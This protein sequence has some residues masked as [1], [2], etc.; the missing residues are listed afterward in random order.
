[1]QSTELPL[2]DAF[3]SQLHSCSLIEKDYKEWVHLVKSGL[4]A[5]QTFAKL[6]LSKPLPSRME[7][8]QNLPEISEEE[9][10]GSVRDILH[11]CNKKDDVPILEAMQKVIALYNN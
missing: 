4:T 11:W 9:N 6:K 2:F 1:M 10:S 8:Y 3:Y 5:E 7:N